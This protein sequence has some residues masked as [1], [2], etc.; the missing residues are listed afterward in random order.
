MLGPSGA[1]LE[2]GAGGLSKAHFKDAI[3]QTMPPIYRPYS[4]LLYEQ[5]R[6]GF[7]HGLLPGPKVGLTHRD[8]SVKYETTHLSKRGGAVTVVV[9][10]LYDDFAAAC[11]DL[12][13][14]Q[15]PQNDKMSKPL[16]AIP[17]DSVRLAN[18]P[19]QEPLR[20]KLPVP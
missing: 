20:T 12:L 7:A 8:E 9:E 17:S 15:I 13:Q 5:L 19:T 14:R 6:G 11:R 3:E 2:K 18:C 16:L 10:S 1:G 4:S